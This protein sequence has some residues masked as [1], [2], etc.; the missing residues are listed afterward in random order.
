MPR[1][2]IIFVHGRSV[3]PSASHK[4]KLTMNAMLRGLH[5]ASPHAA[6]LVK[7]GKVKFTFAYYGDINNAIMAM[8][9]ADIAASLTD[10]NNAAYNREPCLPYGPHAASLKKLL[11]IKSYDEA[12]YNQI[13]SQYKD[14]RYLDDVARAFSHFLSVIT[15]N[16]AN[17]IILARSSEDMSA[18]LMS[19]KVGSDI[20]NR[21]QNPLRRAIQAGDDICLVSHSMGCVIAYDVLWKFS[22]MSEYEHLRRHNPS[23]TNW[24][25]LGCPFGEVGVRG[26]L[27][28][29][30]EHAG[31][32]FPKSI[33]KHWNNIAA[34]DD[35]IAHNPTMADDYAEML[36]YGYVETITDKRIY[37]CWVHDGKSNP[38]KL[39]GYLANPVVGFEL[40]QWIEG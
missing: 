39:Y 40:A 1:K 13:T 9:D 32:R 35:F 36:Q 10:K 21:L 2:H 22:Q 3:K 15:R 23:I 12:A 19:R 25:T 16:K 7:S 18:Y 24:L 4:K 31:G 28:D 11:A 34:Y 6:E 38:H 30:K 5:A 8:H 17:E 37:N 26:N 20:R 14:L 33:V 29:A 27:Y